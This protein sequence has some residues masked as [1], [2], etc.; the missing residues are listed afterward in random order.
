MENTIRALFPQT[1]HRFCR[2][3]MLKKYKDQLNQIYDQHPKLKDK[4]ISVFNHPLNPEQF[5]AAW[6][7]MCDEF[8]LHDRVTMQALYNDQRIWIA[9]Y[10]KEV[11]CGT[12]QSTQRS[13]SV[14]SMVKGGYLDNSKSVHE[15][16]KC[17]LDVLVHIHDNE[18]KEKYYSHVWFTVYSCSAFKSN[19][20][21]FDIK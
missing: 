21:V 11:F 6:A 17:F 9:A 3:H 8:G 7:E 2:C 5:E 18:T 4:L 10:L 20:L 16:T 19:D 13:E 15:F 1:I 12:I 14:N